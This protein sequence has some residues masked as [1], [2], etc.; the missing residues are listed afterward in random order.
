MI[1]NTPA[2]KTWVPITMLRRLPFSKRNAPP[3]APH[4]HIWSS[5]HAYLVI[6]SLTDPPWATRDRSGPC[7]MQMLWKGSVSGNGYCYSI[8]ICNCPRNLLSSLRGLES[9]TV[10]AGIASP[11]CG[12]PSSS[13]CLSVC[14][15]VCLFVCFYRMLLPSFN[16]GVSWIESDD[17]L[18]SLPSFVCD[19]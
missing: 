5:Q 13:L 9:S 4:I 1:K 2:V 19:V 15:S 11:L 12:T 14:P 8:F 16:K 18:P 7:V 10:E 6:L 17:V 3:P